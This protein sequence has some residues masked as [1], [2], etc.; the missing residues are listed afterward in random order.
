MNETLQRAW[1]RYVAV[2]V[3][4]TV[5]HWGTLAALVE[6]AML[7]AWL[8]SGAGAL[9][10]AQVAFVGNRRWT[11]GHRGALVPAWLRF[12]L[13]AVLGGALG[14]AIVAVGVAAGLHYLLAQ[15]LAT[16]TVLITGFVVNRAWSFAP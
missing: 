1:W 10:G 15:A 13:T 16:S 7:P 14:M 5:A 3:L 6:R 9:V 4:A 8:A 2:G 11:F 12:M